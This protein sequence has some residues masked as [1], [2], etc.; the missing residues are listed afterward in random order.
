MPDG[1]AQSRQRAAQAASWEM[2][3]ADEQ[4]ELGQCLV[5]SE[6]LGPEWVAAFEQA[7]RSLFLPDLMWP[8][9]DDG[10]YR[11][12]DRVIDPVA[13]R[14]WAFSDVPI[15]TQWD[16][17]R[18]LGDS[19]GEEPTSS[20]SM[21]SL[22][23]S[24]F[25]DL[26]V[27]DGA[28]VLE[29]GTGTGWCAGLLSARLGDRQVVSVEVDEKV[30]EAARR[31]LTAAGWSPTVL[32]GDGADGWVHDAPYDRVLAT[33]G[34]REVPVAWV[35]Q[36]RPG[37]VV[38]VPWG[39]SYSQHDAIVRLVVGE[40]G[41]ASGRF[42]GGAGFMKLREQRGVWPAHEDYV[43]GGAWP[44]QVRESATTLR[45]EEVTGT[46]EWFVGLR[47]PQVVHTLH[48]G[49]DGTTALLLYGLTDRSWAAVFFCGDGCREF[50][51]YQDGPRDLW[52][53]V[54]A[55]VRWWGG[56]GRPDVTR[57]GMTVSAGEQVVWLDSPQ[58]GPSV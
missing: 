50:L 5:G 2:I 35:E 24:M 28:R 8:F 45:L 12:V 44:A 4:G 31:A 41:T 55:A 37:G 10:E 27:R 49:D 3:P 39:T 34:V 57:F 43:P 6:V 1:E 7:P 16:E 38:V 40:D 21:P 18:H 58:G 48:E 26:D 33:A 29:I 56:Q 46:V 30:A 53:E 23:F 14:R 54:A 15:V 11:V 22:V 51:V 47:V 13:W 19:P 32:T 36:T 25:G 42:T 52:D 20:G 9:G 17:G